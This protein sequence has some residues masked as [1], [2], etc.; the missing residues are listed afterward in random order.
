MRVVALDVGD[1]TIGVAASDELGITAQPLSTIRRTNLE[2]DLARL[3]EILRE[4]ETERLVVGLP[5]NMDDTEGPRAA[6]TR[7]FADEL[8][9]RFGLPVVLW[10]ERL[11][12]WEAERA[13]IEAGVRRKKR[14]SVIDTAA[15]QVILRSYLDAGAPERGK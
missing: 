9:R 13:L 7:R 12:T 14:K 6:R 5:L 3:G 15:A 4:R 8:A 1:R 10:D 11:S 2:R